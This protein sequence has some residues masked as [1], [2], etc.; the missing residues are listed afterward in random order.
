M[1]EV[2]KLLRKII[3][4]QKEYRLIPK[5]S[6]LLLAV[7]GGIDSVVLTYSLLELKDFFKFK[8]LAI[9]HFN[10]RIRKDADEDEKF[11]RNLAKK[12]SLEFFSGSSDVPKI[13][14][15]SGR[16]LEEVAREE[17][18]KFLRNI[19]E[20]EGF[21]FIATAHHLNDLVET[22]LIWLV[23]GSA[24]EGLLGFE[25]KEGDIVRPL[26]LATRKEI[27]DYARVKKLE[28]REDI[29]NYD[30]KIFR[31]KLRHEIIPV[32]KEVNPNLEETIF[33]MREV[34]KDE[35]SFLKERTKEVIERAKEGDNC[36][37]V[38][39]LKEVHVSIQRRVIVEFFSIRNY[40]KVE[41]VRRL[42][43]KGGEVSI[44]EGV[45]VVRKG[46]LICLK[47]EGI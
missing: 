43:E 42:L 8:R 46:K 47:K 2:S 19:K 15:G 12:L 7:S 10:H 28:W 36:L 41:Q 29:T 24:L 22:V 20:K 23:R 5:D 37:R 26:Y 9:A 21:N 32:L 13:A 38:K 18:Y 1:K 16:N 14:K 33:R 17:R 44:K 45:K 31:N 35:D 4:L 40:S 25:P 30:T 39:A 34:L 27:E 6:S 11:V 3:K